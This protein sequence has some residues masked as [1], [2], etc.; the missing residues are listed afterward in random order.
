MRIR[1]H[2]PDLLGISDKVSYRAAAVVTRHALLLLILCTALSFLMRDV[3]ASPATQNHQPHAQHS[4]KHA[5]EQTSG[6]EKRLN[7]IFER[8]GPLSV[9]LLMVVSGAGI[10][11]PEDMVIIPAGWE[12]AKGH[13]SLTHTFL[14][15]YLG[16]AIGDAGWFLLCRFFG[17]RLLRSTWLLRAVHPRRILEMKYLIDHYGAWVLVLCRLI[18][19]TRTPALTVGGLMHLN[20]W[21]FLAVE[22]PMVFL[23]VGSQL[24]LGYFAARG[25]EIGGFWQK[26]LLYLGLLLAA[27]LIVFMF[28][29][30]RKIARGEICLPR[31]SMQW[32]HKIRKR[33]HD[34]RAAMRN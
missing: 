26:L 22:L 10:H 9:F 27:S 6:I 32:L 8:F 13:F 16:V 5:P 29:I 14:A 18:P 12:I 19:G 2:G 23:T 7:Q 25:S 11:F 21:I 33:S 4:I 30:R 3:F 20:G 34:G 1:T 28:T 15:A 17:T 24:A 31:A